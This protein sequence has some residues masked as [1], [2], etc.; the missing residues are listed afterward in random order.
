MSALI[1]LTVTTFR[2]AATTTAGSR[3]CIATTTLLPNPTGRVSEAGNVLHVKGGMADMRFDIVSPTSNTAY[4]AIG[5]YFQGP[6]SDPLG[7][8]SFDLGN[9]H[10]QDSE[11]GIRNKWAKHGPEGSGG[12]QYKAFIVVQ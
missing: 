11:V 2:N 5:I 4:K 8:A 10:L 12:V 1:T 6:G 9:L 7:E 3:Y